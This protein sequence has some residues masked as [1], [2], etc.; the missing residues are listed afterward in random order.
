MLINIIIII[1][2]FII[3]IIRLL[4]PG[5]RRGRLDH[6]LAA[7]LHELAVGLRSYNSI[8][9]NIIGLGL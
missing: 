6:L 9:R 8:D 2:M 3:I 7:A 5:A 1:I 4:R